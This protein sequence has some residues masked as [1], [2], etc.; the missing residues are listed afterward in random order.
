MELIEKIK[1]KTLL[2]D[3][4]GKRRNNR[5]DTKNDTENRRRYCNKAR[6]PCCLIEMNEINE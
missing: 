4:F 5:N 2:N 3:L 6:K 1:T